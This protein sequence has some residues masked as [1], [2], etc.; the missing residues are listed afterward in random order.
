[1]TLRSGGAL[2]VALISYG[3]VA[4]AQGGTGERGD[5][6]WARGVTSAQQ[7][8][9]MGLFSTGNALFTES[10]YA[11]ALAQY[12]EALRSWDH[13]AI[14]YNAAVSLINLD[15]PLAAYGELEAALAYD[16][17]PL[18]EENH[19]QALLYRKL[20]AGQLAELAVACDEPEAE[21]MLDGETLFKAPGKTTRRLVPGAHQLVARKAGFLTETRALQVP[22]GKLT[23]EML[24]LHV[25]GATPMR[26]VRRWPA[27]KPW[28][29]LGAGALVALIGV[30]LMLEAR[31]NFDTFDSD[32][33]KLCPSGCT[34]DQLPSTVFASRDRGR[35]ENQIA[36]GLLATGGAAAATG[37]V[38]LI[39]NQPRLE[40][41]YGAT[42]PP[43]AL[44]PLL[45]GGTTGL[46]ATLR[47]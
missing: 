23:S 41:D 24:S 45:G 2:V 1:M 8:A 15:Q 18:G 42:P 33:A 10:K 27:W 36:I 40:P 12:R 44:A 25:I 11:A 22:P 19:R 4:S 37:V 13:P 32:L 16:E 35:L 3:A 21:V 6:P 7:E 43:L 39:L 30:P 28:T 5:R 31:T 47:F 38:L 34:R 14:H 29:V 9:A 20:L 46:A 26:S 17:A